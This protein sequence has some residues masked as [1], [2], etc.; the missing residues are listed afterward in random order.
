MPKNMPTA[1]SQ[2]SRVETIAFLSYSRIDKARWDTCVKNSPQFL[3]YGLSWYLDIVSPQWDALI[4]GDYEAVMPLTWQRKWGVKYLS[5]PLFAQQLGV[6]GTANY[7]DFL[8]IACRYFP[9]NVH[10]S[11][12]QST[13]SHTSYFISHTFFNTHILDLS[14]PYSYINEKCY[15]NDRRQNL[16][17]ANKVGW[18]LL[19]SGDINPLISLFEQNHA[20]QIEGGVSEKAYPMLNDLFDAIE[21]QKLG[22]LYYAVLNGKIEAGVW[23]VFSGNR[24]IYLFNAA[25]PVGRQGNAR[26]FLIDYLIRQYANKPYLL[27]FE[28]PTIE[29][30]DSFYASF[31]AK[32][33]SYLQIKWNKLPTIINF[34]W[35]LKKWI[36]M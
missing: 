23:F 18:T 34:L 22:I 8:Q 10:Y 28:S 24:I 11:L 14:Q 19:M 21:K 26:T 12:Q 31:G 29:S 30:I 13:I 16:K 17:R 3:I 7:N 4:L 32:A 9:L 6:F 1:K 33:A 25:S 20:Q 35:Q 2:P 27:D 5:Q 36:G 15:N